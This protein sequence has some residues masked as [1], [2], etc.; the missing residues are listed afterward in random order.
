MHQLHY[1][2]HKPLGDTIALWVL[3]AAWLPDEPDLLG[4]FPPVSAVVWGPVIMGDAV[5]LSMQGPDPLQAGLQLVEGRGTHHCYLWP[6]A[7]HVNYHMEVVRLP[8]PYDGA[9]EVGRQVLPHLLWGLSDHHR[10]RAVLGAGCCTPYV[11]GGHILPYVLRHAWPPVQLPE[12]PHHGLHARV[13]LVCR[14]QNLWYQGL[15]QH[16]FLSPHNHLSGC[17]ELRETFSVLFHPGFLPECPLLD[18]LHYCL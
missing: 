17:A 3:W 16:Q 18:V 10:G 2:A 4:I 14:L 7:E 12:L 5:W 9:F 8:I 13:P 1:H 15:G 6:S 11:A